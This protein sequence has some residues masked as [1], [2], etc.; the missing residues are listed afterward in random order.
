M[1]KPVW[2]H[3]FISTGEV[4][5]WMWLLGMTG[6][7]QCIISTACMLPEL[8]EWVKIRTPQGLWS[9][10]GLAAE[11][12]M[13]FPEGGT[14]RCFPKEG[15][16]YIQVGLGGNNLSKPTTK[17]GRGGVGLFLWPLGYVGSSGLQIPCEVRH[18][19]VLPLCCK[20]MEI[21]VWWNFQRRGPTHSQLLSHAQGWCPSSLFHLL[22]TRT[23]G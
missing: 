21:T 17:K 18:T 6:G 23:A 5:P 4:I 15:S 3:S 12:K 8:Q 13:W 2:L 9:S 22:N 1:Q 7:G 19:P 20:P 11:E 10:G 14:C 16:Q